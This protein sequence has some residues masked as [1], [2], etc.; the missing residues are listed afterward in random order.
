MAY[1]IPVLNL[2]FNAGADLSASAYLVGTLN[3]SGLIVPST[4]AAAGGVGIIQDAVLAGRSTVVMALGVSKAVYGAAVA[5][6]G[7]KLTNDTAG[8]LIPVALATDVIVAT[9]LEAGA[10]NEQHAVL[11]K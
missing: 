9:A 4:T 3:G 5:T 10:T 1:E 6:P 8:K 11:L 2:S 7:L